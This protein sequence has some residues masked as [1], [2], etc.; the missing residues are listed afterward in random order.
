MRGTKAARGSMMFKPNCFAISYP[1][2]VAPILGIDLPPVAITTDWQEKLLSSVVRV[3]PTSVLAILRILVFSWM[4]T[5]TAAHSA[6]NISMI[7]REDLSQKS[8][9]RVFS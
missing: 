2:P 4:A 7:W 1:K 5:F 8:W 9:P 6:S 3:N